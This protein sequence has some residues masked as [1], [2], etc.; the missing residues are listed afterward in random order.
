MNTASCPQVFPRYISSLL[1]DG[2]KTGATGGEKT[3][4]IP[5]SEKPGR[6]SSNMNLEPTM[7]KALAW[8]A[9]GGHTHLYMYPGVPMHTHMHTHTCSAIR[10]ALPISVGA[11]KKEACVSEGTQGQEPGCAPSW[12]GDIGQ[13]VHHS[14]SYQPHL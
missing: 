3:C 6:A 10:P 1:G 8:E 2:S 13:V 7:S 9:D 12:L 11:S 5:D 14:R 4:S